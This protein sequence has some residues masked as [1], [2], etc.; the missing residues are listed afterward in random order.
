[1]LVAACAM[2]LATG[3]EKDAGDGFEKS[4]AAIE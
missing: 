4:V 1:M 2:L 3:H